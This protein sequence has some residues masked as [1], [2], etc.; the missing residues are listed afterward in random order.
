MSKKKR[1]PRR[2]A[3]VSVHE[4]KVTLKGSKPAIWR[5][6]AVAGDTPM[7]ELH[8]VLQ[9]VMGWT[10]SHLHQFVVAKLQ[11]KPTREEISTLANAGQWEKLFGRMQRDRAVSDPEFELDD[12]EDEFAVTLEEVAPAVKSKFTYEY[13]FGDGWEHKVE[14]V[15]IRPPTPGERYPTCLSGKM[16]CPPED[17]GGVWG[18]YD[19]IEAVRDP[20]HERHAELIEWLGDDFDPERFD[21]DEVNEVLAELR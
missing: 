5:R 4:L 11:P 10:N 7:S 3:P 19:L 21:L 8:W 1:R 13:D 9:I 20:K 2:A 17:C 16:A 15:K 18:Y 12:T 6:V 14:V